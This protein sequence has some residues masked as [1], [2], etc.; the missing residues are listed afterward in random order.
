MPR[1]RVGGD[2]GAHCSAHREER[3]KLGK[4][5]RW[6]D[7]DK[8]IWRGEGKRRYDAVEDFFL[9]CNHTICPRGINSHITS[10]LEDVELFAQRKLVIY[11]SPLS[12]VHT[13]WGGGG[14]D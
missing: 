14:D 3:Q 1:M 7:S 4:I 12:I 2:W 9:Y 8:P 6:E 5:Q 11:L 13:A 10:V